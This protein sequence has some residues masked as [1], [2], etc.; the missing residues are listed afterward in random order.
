MSRSCAGVSVE[1]LKA[2][3]PIKIYPNPND[4]NFRVT[5]PTTFSSRSILLVVDITGRVCDQRKLNGISEVA[6]DLTHLPSGLYTLVLQ[7]EVQ[8]ASDKISIQ[9]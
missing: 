8:Q 5:L 1:E 7:G 9:H 2:G 3:E 6:L 4:G